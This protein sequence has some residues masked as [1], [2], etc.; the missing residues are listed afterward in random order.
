VV[1]LL[2]ERWPEGI[3]EKDPAGSTPLHWAA[4]C[5]NVEAVK[6]LLE[7]WPEATRD[8]SDSG[9]TPLHYAAAG[10]GN[11]DVMRLLVER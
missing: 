6:L 4:H 8:K 9:Y 1:R 3:R 2:L 10:I 5:G 7:R 11:T